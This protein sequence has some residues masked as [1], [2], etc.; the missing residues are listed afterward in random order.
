MTYAVRIRRTGCCQSSLRGHRREE[1]KH[2]RRTTLPSGQGY[3]RLELRVQSQAA[4]PQVRPWQHEAGSMRDT[5]RVA[6]EQGPPS[7]A[8]QRTS[9]TLLKK[10]H[11]VTDSQHCNQAQQVTFAELR[12]VQGSPK[13]LPASK[14][15]ARKPAAAGL[16][17]KEDERRRQR[18]GQAKPP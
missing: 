8:Q 11:V 17:A 3:G 10:G 13:E 15:V 12:L 18:R 6:I 16:T 7:A 2:S 4:Q 5:P 9:R 1:Y 14:P